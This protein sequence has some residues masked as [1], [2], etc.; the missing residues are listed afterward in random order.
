MT[1][2]GHLCRSESYI[3]EWLK[4]HLDEEFNDVSLSKIHET[5]IG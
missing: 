2:N 3:N 5:N 1:Q 4:Q